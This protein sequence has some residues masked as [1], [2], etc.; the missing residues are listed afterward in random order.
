MDDYFTP[1]G[2]FFAHWC[3]KRPFSLSVNGAQTRVLHTCVKK[4]SVFL[5]SYGKTLMVRQEVYKRYKE[6][7]N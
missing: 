4:S 3:E 2:H 6:D 1:K 5:Q 7:S